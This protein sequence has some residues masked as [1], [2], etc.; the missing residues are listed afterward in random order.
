M[1]K[2]SKLKQVTFWN[3]GYSKNMYRRCNIVP[4]EKYDLQNKNF[5]IIYPVL[6]ALP[7]TLFSKSF[8]G[9]P[10]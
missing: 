3:N 9:F 4:P 7:E 5:F 6:S 10:V 8:S 2:F 1:Y